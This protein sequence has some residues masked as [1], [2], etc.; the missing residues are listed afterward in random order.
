M[1][2]GVDTRPMAV[3]KPLSLSPNQLLASLDTGFFKNAQ[4]Q[5]HTMWPKNHSQTVVNEDIK[6][7]PD[8]T[9]IMIDPI[10]MQGLR[11]QFSMIQIDAKFKGK[12]TI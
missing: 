1:P 3:A 6:R 8:P 9:I 7:I 12:Y 11:P 5:A 10:E 2:S 4:L